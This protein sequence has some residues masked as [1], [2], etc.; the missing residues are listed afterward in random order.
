MQLNQQQ[1][2]QTQAYRRFQHRL[3]I[4]GEPLYYVVVVAKKQ[5]AVPG[6]WLEADDALTAEA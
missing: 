2:L 1:I 3:S 4:T 5:A 6:E